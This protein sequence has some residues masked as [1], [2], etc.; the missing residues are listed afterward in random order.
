MTSTVDPTLDEELAALGEDDRFDFANLAFE[1][2]GVEGCIFISSHSG[3][4]GPRIKW[5]QNL[6]RDEP[7]FSISI[8]E[9]PRVL[10]SAVSREVLERVAPT[11]FQWIMLNRK[12]LLEFWETGECWLVDDVNAF[13]RTLAKVPVGT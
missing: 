5:R 1:R 9:P 11:V 6:N 10:G 12:S 2:T 4:R 8:T 3:E 13:L 7:T